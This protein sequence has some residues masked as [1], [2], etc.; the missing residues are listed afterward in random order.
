MIDRELKK[1]VQTVTSD[2]VPVAELIDGVIVRPQVTQLDGRGTLCEILDL[3]WGFADSTIVSV[4]QFTIRPGMA[5]GWHVHR[6][7]D[8][9][10]F[11]SRGELKVVLYDDREGSPTHGVINEVHRT[12]LQRTLMVI[13]RGVFHAHVNVGATD[14][15]LISMPTRAYDHADPDVFRLPLDTDLIPYSFEDRL[16]W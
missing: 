11:I 7:H 14:A 16:G 8:D 4:Y 10:I 3:R 9:R 6:Q 15:L 2:G 5:K 13:P 1:D 12:E